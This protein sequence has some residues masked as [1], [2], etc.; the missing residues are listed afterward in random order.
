[1]RA[2]LC[3]F[4]VGIALAQSAA[5]AANGAPAGMAPPPSRGLW[6]WLKP[7]SPLGAAQ[8]LGQP[9]REAEAIATFQRW[10]VGRLYGS[11]GSLPV[12]SPAAM[13]AWN[14]RLHVGGVRS[15]SLFSNGAALTPAG[16]AAFLA[17]VRTR[18]VDFNAARRDPSE[19]FD[20]IALDIEPHALAQ[21]KAGSAAD[22]RGLLDSYLETCTA[23][24]AALD[25]AGAG[26]LTISAALAYWLD[27]LPP[28]GRV[29]WASERDRDDW[30]KRLAVVVPTISLMAYERS[31]PRQI[32]EASEWERAHFPGRTI[33]A[34]RARLGVE[35]KALGDLRAVLPAVESGSAGGVDLENY[36]LLRAAEDRDGNSR[37]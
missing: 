31:Q 21:W 24:R 5:A 7:S 17:E 22:R 16:R 28:V 8:V 18:V 33:T 34:L 23:L 20:G 32:L 11:Y 36:E 6:F 3:L 15:E 25:Q 14:H 29:G 19:R 26:S 30:F 13:A 9:E 37:R 4:L 35:W 10:A 2:W 12:E 27:R 1:M